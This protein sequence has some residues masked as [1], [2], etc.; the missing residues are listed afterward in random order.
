MNFEFIG[1]QGEIAI[2]HD[3]I[4]RQHLLKTNDFDLSKLQAIVNSDLDI[5]AQE[6]LKTILT[7]RWNRISE[8][9][10][11]RI[12]NKFGTYLYL[13][14]DSIPNVHGYQMGAYTRYNL[15]CTDREFDALIKRLPQMITNN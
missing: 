14:E 8:L 6:Y 9:N 12:L 2:V 10:D 3:P 1:L 4:I 7:N 15:L 13:H 11:P 5:I